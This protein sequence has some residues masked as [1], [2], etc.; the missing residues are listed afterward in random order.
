MRKPG[1]VV[2]SSPAPP[3]IWNRLTREQDRRDAIAAGFQRH[4]SK[5]VDLVALVQTVADLVAPLQVL[6]HDARHS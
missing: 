3:P 5:P 4:L 6:T 2:F 1:S